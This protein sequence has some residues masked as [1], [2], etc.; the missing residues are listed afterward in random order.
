MHTA[1]PERLQLDERLTFE[2]LLQWG[3]VSTD[4]V[5]D[6]SARVSP[7]HSRNA[8]YRVTTNDSSLFVKLD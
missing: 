4:S 7:M 8:N 3:L 5:I 1:R 2:K 6:G